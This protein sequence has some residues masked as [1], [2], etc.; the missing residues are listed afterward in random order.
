MSLN[1]DKC[2]IEVPA[3]N[4]AVY[5]D[6]IIT[7]NPL[8]VLAVSRHLL[9]LIEDGTTVCAGSPS[10]AQYIEGQPRDLRGDFPYNNSMEARVRL[11]YV[12]LL[13]MA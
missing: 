9:P 4:N 13:K 1:C 10:R 2:G 6:I 11:A 7:Q 3:T 12:K 8:L 5:L